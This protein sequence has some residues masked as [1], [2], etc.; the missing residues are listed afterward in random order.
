MPLSWLEVGGELVFATFVF[1]CAL[2]EV[3]H[4]SVIINPASSFA[5]AFPAQVLCIFTCAAIGAVASVVVRPLVSMRPLLQRNRS[6]LSRGGDYVGG[7]ALPYMLALFSR[8]VV[9]PL[10]F[11]PLLALWGA[12]KGFVNALIQ[13]RHTPNVDGLATSVGVLAVYGIVAVPLAVGGVLLTWSLFGATGLASGIASDLYCLFFSVKEDGPDEETTGGGLAM[14][15]GLLPRPRDNRLL[16][17]QP[18]PTHHRDG[19]DHHNHGGAAA[20][21]APVRSA[22]DHARTRHA[23]RN[24]ARIAARNAAA[25]IASSGNG[26]GRRLEGD[27]R[28][29]Q[30]TAERLYEQSEVTSDDE[31]DIEC[32]DDGAS[33]CDCGLEDAERWSGAIMIDNAAAASSGVVIGLIKV[34][35]FLPL[36]AMVLTLEFLWHCVGGATSNAPIRMRMTL[37]QP[38]QCRPSHVELQRRKFLSV[39]PLLVSLLSGAA[40]CTSDAQRSAAPLLSLY[41]IANALSFCGLFSGAEL[42]EDFR[43]QAETEGGSSDDIMLTRGTRSSPLL[44]GGARVPLARP[45][46][47]VSGTSTAMR[48]PLGKD[49]A[50][51]PNWIQRWVFVLLLVGG[52]ATAAFTVAPM[53]ICVTRCIVDQPFWG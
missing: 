1:L 42:S 32:P 18:Q 46:P 49:S 2:D 38:A 33:L 51:A 39:S 52:N 24:A 29:R 9:A 41:L 22:V 3:T 34:L 26:S 15:R 53:G 11:P 7:V 48:V 43:G 12:L 28:H 25:G 36:L 44:V 47:V 23:P 21:E 8:F 4:A 16:Q 17:P 45:T 50:H 13:G 37:R 10:A 30:E 35:C 40:L 31:G 6:W 27:Q 14:L 20:E 19:D 5:A